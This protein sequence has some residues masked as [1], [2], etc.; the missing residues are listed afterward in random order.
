MVGGKHRVSEAS[1][2]RKR[3]QPRLCGWK[4]RQENCRKRE[5]AWCQTPPLMSRVFKKKVDKP[6]IRGANKQKQEVNGSLDYCSSPA[7][8]E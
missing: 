8:V 5:P 2:Q 4:K 6:K 7:A 3:A 1:H